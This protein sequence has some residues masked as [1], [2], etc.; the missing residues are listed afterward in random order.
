MKLFF[1][2]I[3]K[4]FLGVILVGAF[5]FL[6]AGTFNFVQ[7]WLFMAVLFVVIH[8]V[9]YEWLMAKVHRRQMIYSSTKPQ[10]DNPI[11]LE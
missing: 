11:C 8:S 6:S 5:I 3:I 7:G 2:A 1:E 4:F 10:P 9:N